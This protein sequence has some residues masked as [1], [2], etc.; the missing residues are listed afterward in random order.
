MTNDDLVTKLDKLAAESYGF[1]SGDLQK[2]RAEAL[3]RYLCEP[4]GD[5][6]EGRSSVVST[7]LRDVVEWI[8]PQW[9]KITMS[10]DKVVK[11]EP[12]GP[13]DEKQAELETDYVHYVILQRNDALT[14]LSTWARDA[15]ISMN[16]YA[17]A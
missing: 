2:K 5:E 10:G 17:K 6:V 4:R 11:F 16:G 14:F 9:L 15:L 3:R 8:V 7:D 12:T 1:D 13:E